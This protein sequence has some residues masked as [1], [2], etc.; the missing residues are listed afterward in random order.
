MQIGK[1]KLA[2]AI[3]GLWGLISLPMSEAIY[4][5]VIDQS[6]LLIRLFALLLVLAPI[7]IV[8][9]WRWLTNNRPMRWWFWL[10]GIAI[11]VFSSIYIEDQSYSGNLPLIPLAGIVV[12][13][14]LVWNFERGGMLWWRRKSLD[15][16]LP[17]RAEFQTGVRSLS[18]L[19]E[20]IANDIHDELCRLAP[21]LKLPIPIH[22]TDALSCAYGLVFLNLDEHGFNQKGSKLIAVFSGYK[23]TMIT[24]YISISTPKIPGIGGLTAAEMKKPEIRNPARELLEMKEEAADTVRDNLSRN[25]T[26]PFYP[27]YD[28]MRLYVGKDATASELN[29]TFDSVFSKWNSKA[30]RGVVSLLSQMA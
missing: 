12:F 23:S 6:G 1:E 29:A 19:T 13:L 16:V 18:K 14:I 27:F 22:Q 28:G 2:Y 5:D 20:E 25:A 8:F 7:W 26:Y 21:N 9:G 17:D 3:S 24:S 10:A 30:K 15:Q 4:D 11:G